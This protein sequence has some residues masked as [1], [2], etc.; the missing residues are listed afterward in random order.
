M[1]L[2][3][4]L[5]VQ[6]KHTQEGSFTFSDFKN[7]APFLT[8]HSGIELK[9]CR[10]PKR[11]KKKKKLLPSTQNPDTTQEFSGKLKLS[12]TENTSTNE[13]M[14]HISSQFHL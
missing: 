11:Q 9:Q 1:S 8:A 7:T 6:V 5:V 13:P 14:R 10:S 3:C 12:T 2:K 4:H